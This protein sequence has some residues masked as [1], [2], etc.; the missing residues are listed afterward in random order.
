MV[1]VV[2]M[3]AVQLRRLPRGILDLDA[4]F[5]AFSR[6]LHGL[7]VDLDAGDNADVDEL[8]QKCHLSVKVLTDGNRVK[9]LQRWDA[10]QVGELGKVDFYVGQRNLQK[11]T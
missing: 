3:A 7:M 9:A 1:G 6:G 11:P 4:D 2:E 8:Q 5:H 10:W